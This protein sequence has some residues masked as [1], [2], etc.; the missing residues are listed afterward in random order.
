[1]NFYPDGLV[2]DSGSYRDGLKEGLRKYYN[3]TG[4]LE[5]TVNYK[6]GKM[7]GET[8]LY[9]PLGNVVKVEYFENGVLVEQD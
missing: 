6:A 4:S 5:Y 2:S 8:T 1:M 7:D 9:S 3:E